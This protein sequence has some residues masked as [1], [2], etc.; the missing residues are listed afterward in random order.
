MSH[1]PKNRGSS[2]DRGGILESVTELKIEKAWLRDPLVDW[3][4]T[5]LK[6]QALP[7]VRG[8]RFV[9]SSAPNIAEVQLEIAGSSFEAA[10]SITD[11]FLSTLPEAIEGFTARGDDQP[12]AADEV[13][14]MGTGLAL[15]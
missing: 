8:V 15:A 7:S 10:E 6:N 13:Q 4:N 14:I 3:L 11:R 2:N 12:L 5:S 9:P 1:M